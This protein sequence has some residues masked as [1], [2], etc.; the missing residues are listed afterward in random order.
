MANI[1][2]HVVIAPKIPPFEL[3]N[4]PQPPLV[5]PSRPP[6]KLRGGEG[7]VM[8]EGGGGELFSC[9]FAVFLLLFFSTFSS[10]LLPLPKRT[11]LTVSRTISISRKND[12]FFM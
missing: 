4:A 7:G 9:A 2:I 5:N 3:S 1:R 6:L 11:T 8:S 10:Y 12:R